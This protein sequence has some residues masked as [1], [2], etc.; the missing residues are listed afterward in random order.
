[1]GP[2]EGGRVASITGVPGDLRVWYLGAASGGI[3][4]SVDSGATFR[5][6]FDSMPVQAI[7]A[8]AVAPSKPSIVWAGTGE[9]WAIRDADLFGDGV[10]KSSDSGATWTNIGPRRDGPHS[11]HHRASDESRHRVRLR[12]RPRDGPAAGARRLPHDRRRQDAGSRCCSSTRTPAVPGLTMDPKNPNVLFAGTWEV[13]MHTWAMFSGGP[14]SGIY[15]TRDGGTTWKKVEHPGLP[16]SPLGKIDVAVAPT[17][18]K[19]VYALIQTADQGSLWRSRRRRRVVAAW[20]T[21]SVLSL[22]APATTSTSRCRA[23]TPTRSSSRTSSF[24]RSTDGGKTFVEVPWGGDNHD[25]WIDPKNPNHFGLT[26]DAGARLTTD[27]GKTFQSVALPIGQMYHVAVDN[28]MPYWVYGNRQDNGTMRGPSTAPEGATATRGIAAGAGRGGRGGGR[29][30]DCDGRRGGA[31]DAAR[32]AARVDTAAA[33]LR[34]ATAATRRTW[35]APRI[36]RR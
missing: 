15:V 27:H 12:A 16:K 17:N 4:K 7:G 19:R 34:R 36:L 35:C 1:M 10:Y 24:F 8:L 25:I 28:Q 30:N 6:V 2:A 11:A 14:G 22:A 5:P 26:N 23:A 20:S 31:V 33:R 18:S 13:V 29:G 32:I 21:I 3:W 9:A